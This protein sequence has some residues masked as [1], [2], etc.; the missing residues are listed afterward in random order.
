ME[1]VDKPSEEQITA[2]LAACF[3][4]T[5]MGQGVFQD[6]LERLLE[7]SR[8]RIS[9]GYAVC[10]YASHFMESDEHERIFTEEA[11]GWEKDIKEKGLEKFLDEWIALSPHYSYLSI[12]KE[13]LP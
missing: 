4:V 5:N 8:H 3:A 13:K 12:F 1:K 9:A 7:P 10:E 2:V 6:R 11:E